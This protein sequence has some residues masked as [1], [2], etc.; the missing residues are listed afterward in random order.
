MGNGESRSLVDLLSFSNNVLIG[1]NAIHRDIEVDHLVCCDRR[2]VKE[3]QLNLK[4]KK[5]KIYTRPE[6]SFE[7]HNVLEVPELPY[8][9]SSRADKQWHWGSGALA[10]LLACR[11]NFKEINLFGFDLQGNNGR[12]NNLYK[13]TSNYSGSESQAVDPSYWI[14][15]ISKI[16]ECFPNNDFI[17]YN[18]KDWQMPAEW[19][20]FNVKFIAL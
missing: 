4:N 12:I 15:H 11:L 1:C 5:T 18:K 10:V 6:W 3:A 13:G 7:F 17:F 16:I 19:Q 8:K 14:Y 2:M 9:G 20:K